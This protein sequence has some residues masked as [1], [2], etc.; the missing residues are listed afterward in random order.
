MLKRTITGFFILLFVVGFTA[1]REVSILFFDALVLTLMYGAVIEI[2]QANK[3]A[4]KQT[5]K[6]VLAVYPVLLTLIY[7]LSSSVLMSFALQIALALIAFCFLMAKELITHAINRKNGTTIENIDE[8]NASLLNETKNTMMVLAYP[9]TLL[10]FLMGLNHLGLEVGYVLIILTFA[11]S[12]MTDVFAYLFGSLIKGP[13]MAP[14]IS[15]KKSISGMICGALGGIIASGLGY[16]LFVTFGYFNAFCNIDN[17][18]LITL[19][20]LVGVVGT[21]LTQ[22]G[23]LVASAYKRKV[24]IKD[25]GSIFPGHGGFMDRVDGLMFTGSWIYV[26]YIFLTLL[27]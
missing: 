4:N 7:I 9:T 11:V 13:K 24:G 2:A 8:L 17:G 14:E 25:F 27:I 22:F 21:F 26:V 15:P 23:D 1:L 5:N 18:I 3:V 6:I 12:M 16:L 20:V 19:F 10:G